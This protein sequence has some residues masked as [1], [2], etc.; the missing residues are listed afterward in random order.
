[1]EPKIYRITFNI[2]NDTGHEM[3]CGDHFCNLP[4]IAGVSTPSPMTMQ[5]PNN[6]TIS[7]AVRSLLY[8]SKNLFSGEDAIVCDDGPYLYAES[9]SS[10]AC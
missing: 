7:R 6:T 4:E 2:Q 8:F 5:A 1:M 9:S 3:T 10:A